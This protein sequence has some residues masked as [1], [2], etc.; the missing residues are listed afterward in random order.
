MWGRAGL[1]GLSAKHPEHIR[2]FRN[3]VEQLHSYDHCYTIFPREAVDK[4]GS[5]SVLLREMFRAYDPRCLPDA[6]FTRNRQLKGSLKVT[7]VKSY[8]DDEKSKTGLSKKGWRLIIMQGCSTFMKALE[9]YDEDFKFALG[10][11]HIYIHGGVRRP[12]PQTNREP[13]TR[14]NNP[15]TTTGTRR[16]SRRTDDHNRSYERHYPHPPGG[17]N[18]GGPRG[19]GR[20]S[21]SGGNTHQ[22]RSPT[23]GG[24]PGP[25][26]RAESKSRR[27]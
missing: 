8:A 22:K 20:G 6:I 14:N 27:T 7:H 19:S 13:S 18:N 3:A 1:I 15:R 21:A 23:K 2:E 12:R 10:S 11:G 25:G 9:D 5:V 17:G 24:W 4:K 16:E 26:R